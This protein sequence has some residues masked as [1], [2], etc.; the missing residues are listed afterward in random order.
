MKH[1]HSAR[2]TMDA[3]EKVPL[4][5]LDEKLRRTYETV[6][7]LYTRP[8]FQGYWS[9]LNKE[10]QERLVSAAKTEGCHSAVQRMFPRLEDIIFDPGRAAGLRMIDISPD[11][12]G[13]DYG[14]MWGNLLLHA[15]KQCE[16]MVGV[17]QTRDSLRFLQHRVKEENVDNCFLVNDDLRGEIPLREMF[18]FALVSG[19]LE[20]VAEEHEVELTKFVTRA[21]R[22]WIK[23]RTDPREVQL[24]FLRM[25]SRNLKRDGRLYLAIENRYD[26]QYLLWKKDPHPELFYTA[27]LPRSLANIVSNVRYGRPY[28]TYLYSRGELE[29][30]IREAGFTDIRQF[31]VFPDY[32]FPGKIIP[33]DRLATC[34]YNVVY[35]SLPTNSVF[36]RAFRKARRQLD[37]IVYKR[38]KLFG[39]S[40]SFIFVARKD[41]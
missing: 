34:S 21:R 37:L 13:I 12:I 22:R 28:V 25:V 23:P 14:C 36:K 33:F 41:A 3:G 30:L 11:D 8:G 38:L 7:G 4:K 17:D 31:A 35:N 19:V 32:R 40:P 29:R 39:L 18:D 16:A 24:N 27:F 9:N 6:D 20:W 5:T 2:P 1:G 26:Y 15:A 10:E